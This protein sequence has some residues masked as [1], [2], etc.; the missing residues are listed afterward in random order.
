M[1][2]NVPTKM[3]GVLST[4]ARGSIPRVLSKN[5]LSIPTY[6]SPRSFISQLKLPLARQPLSAGRPNSDSRG[7]S[8]DHGEIARDALR[9]HVEWIRFS[10]FAVCG[11]V[12]FKVRIIEFGVIRH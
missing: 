11:G 2:N 12:S 6:S 8:L 5:I 3:A 9:T 7:A 4:L 10:R 1:T